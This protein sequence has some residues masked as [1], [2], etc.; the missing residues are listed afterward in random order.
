MTVW[1][2]FHRQFS[3][4]DTALNSMSTG[5]SMTCLFLIAIYSNKRKRHERS[6][7]SA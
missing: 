6:I 2:E 1:N 5:F 4:F 3:L 7:A